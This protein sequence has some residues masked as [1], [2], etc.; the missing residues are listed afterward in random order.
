MK[1]PAVEVAQVNLHHAVAASAVIASRFATEDLGILLIQEPWT[2]RGQVKGLNH[3][4]NKVI[5]D[6]SC[7]RPRACVV[8]KNDI[9]YFCITEFLTQDLVAVQTTLKVDGREL[10]VVLAAAYFPG[11]N[12]NVPPLEVQQLLESCRRKRLPVI[13]GCD[14]NAHNMEW[15]SSDT[16]RRGECLLEYIISADLSIHNVGNE[17][18]FITRVREEVLDITISN[19][20]ASP[21]I[22]QWKVSSEPS[23][24]DHR[25]VRLP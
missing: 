5:W 22:G 1:T 13:L 21:L 17:P 4:N 7:E 10:E 15:G 20:L 19:R 9:N 18:T 12:A 8:L 11:D 14:A 6:L 24:S 23:L 16:N 25:I 2:Y 3:N